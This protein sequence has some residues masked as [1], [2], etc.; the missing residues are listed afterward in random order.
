M[1]TVHHVVARYSEDLS[2]LNAFITN[3]KRVH[4]GT[5]VKTYVYNKGED[6]D[7]TILPP[8]TIVEKL[9][10]VGRESHTYLH[11]ITKYHSSLDPQDVTL[12]TQGEVVGRPS[13]YLLKSVIEAFQIGINAS[14]FSDNVSRI[15]PEHKATKSFRILEW[16][17]G[18][19][20]T[21]NKDNVSYGEWVERHLSHIIPD[22]EGH[23]VKWVVG[24]D[25]AVR[26]DF[27][28]RRSVESYEGLKSHFD[29]E[30]G[31]NPEVGHFFERSWGIIFAPKESQS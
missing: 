28:L 6:F 22:H 18:R 4:L 13:S 30:A 20:C 7:E 23:S 24:S 27:I 12:F 15:A 8:G 25:F 9:P 5:T 19:Q 16:P 2:W 10:N 3:L 31:D 14:A 11:H 21:P 26:H 17:P 1:P 29:D